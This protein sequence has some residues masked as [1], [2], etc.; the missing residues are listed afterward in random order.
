[1]ARLAPPQQSPARGEPKASGTYRIAELARLAGVSVATVKY[2]IREGLLPPAPKKTGRTMGWYDDAYLERLKLIRNLREDHYLPLKVI[3]AILAERG[4]APLSPGDAAVVARIGPGV[5]KTLEPRAQVSRAE[6]IRE[7]Q[8]PAA[9][10]DLL[11]QMGL[12]GDGSGKSHTYSATDLE[13]LD[14]M[15]AAERAGLP[16]KVFPIEGLGHYVELIGELARR[17]V[18]IFSHGAQHLPAADLEALAV[19]GLA[20]TQPVVAAI[21]KKLILRALRAELYGTEKP[22]TKPK[23]KKERP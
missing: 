22:R 11:E 13:L 23:K 3:G 20:I 6:L 4:D 12:I 8:M 21:R 14:A 18:R 16:R 9:E 1:M 17:E 5:L 10:L 7:H 19:R 15:D 2:Y